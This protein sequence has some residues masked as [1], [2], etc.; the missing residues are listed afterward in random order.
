[1]TSKVKFSCSKRE[2]SRVK[3]LKVHVILFV[4]VCIALGQSS[5][6]CTQ[7]QLHADS[8][9]S[10]PQPAVS[11]PWLFYGELL[12]TCTFVFEI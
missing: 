5:S 1:M 3:E 11:S 4:S 2:I 8:S 7:L 6:S 12:H 10:M 9:A